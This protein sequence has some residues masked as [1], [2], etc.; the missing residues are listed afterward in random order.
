MMENISLESFLN[1]TYPVI[2][3][4]INSKII[5][6]VPKLNI[7]VESNTLNEA[8]EIYKKEKVT[9]YNRLAHIEALHLIPSLSEK[10]NNYKQ[11]EIKKILI[12]RVISFFIVL[13]FL[14]LISVIIGHKI[15]KS[16]K[17]INEAFTPVT[18]ERSDARLQ[19]FKEKLTIAAPYIREIKKALNE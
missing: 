5:L 6:F 9:F 14:A 4:E 17:K 2:I 15:S 3:K 10:T 16:T 8:Y 19:R 1:R 18:I 12:E 11:V 7:L 13:I